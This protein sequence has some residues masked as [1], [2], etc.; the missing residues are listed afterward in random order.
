MKTLT[1]EQAKELKSGT[2]IY[3]VTNKNNDGTAQKW[4]VNG[5]VQTW[6]RDPLRV[7][8]PVK[9]GLYRYD[10]ITESELHLITLTEPERVKSFT[11]HNIHI[12]L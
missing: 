1:L 11:K 3:H 7:K 4:K 6:K 10:Y 2:I 9:Y 8:I 5:K 12:D